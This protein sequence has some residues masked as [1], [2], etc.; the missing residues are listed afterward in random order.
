V[1]SLRNLCT[2]RRP[3]HFF[4]KSGAALAALLAATAPVPARAA[5]ATAAPAI[6]AAPSGQ[7]V[8]DFYRLRNGYPLWLSVSAG[9][10]AQ[11]LL[12]L[13]SSANVDGLDPGRYQVEQL[14]QLVDT[15]RNG[16]KKRVEEADRALSAAFVSYVADLRQ[17]PGVG[18][19]YVDVDLKPKPPTPLAALLMAAAA[20]SL[21]DSFHQMGWMHPL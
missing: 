9:D 13:L 15:A 1:K 7:S 17:D 2:G 19:T 6:Q 14:R 18:V 21:S 10:A 5:E 8:A 4:Q 11:Q 12:T 16:K 3:V 20:P